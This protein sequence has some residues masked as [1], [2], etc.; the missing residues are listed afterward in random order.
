MRCW[1]GLSLHSRRSTV[2]R[3]P[4]ARPSQPPNCLSHL[5]FRSGAAALRHQ[6]IPA[7]E[8]MIGAISLKGLSALTPDQFSDIL[9]DYVGRTVQPA[10]LAALTDRIADRARAR[11]YVF[12]TAH[13]APQR[14]TAGVLVVEVDEGRVDR[15]DVDGNGSAAVRAALEPLVNG[16]PVRLADLERRLLIAGDVDGVRIRQVRLLREGDRDVLVVNVSQDSRIRA[17]RF[18]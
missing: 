3:P 2:L 18:A 17:P 8:L 16:K 1:Q 4:P 11:G 12:A 15:L 5:I 13:I 6:L 7:G 14:L 9:G 10:E